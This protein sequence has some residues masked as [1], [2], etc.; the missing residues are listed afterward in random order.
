MFYVFSS[1]PVHLLFACRHLACLILEGVVYYAFKNKAGNVLN[2]TQNLNG[3]I[4]RFWFNATF[5]SRKLFS[6]LCAYGCAH[7][8]RNVLDNA[9]KTKGR[10]R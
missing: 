7:K 5:I 4:D 9:C 2:N 1:L 6:L 8:V 3:S 10:A